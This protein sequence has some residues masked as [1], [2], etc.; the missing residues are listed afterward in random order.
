MAHQGKEPAMPI[1][2]GARQVRRVLDPVVEFLRIEAGGGAVL[3]ATTIAALLLANSPLADGYR[4]EL[5]Q[6]RLHLLSA[7]L[8]V[9][10]F[11]LANAGVVLDAAALSAAWGSRVAWASRSGCW[12]ASWPAWSAPV[13]WAMRLGWG[14]LPDDMT[15]RHLWASGPWPGSASPWPCSSPTWPTARSPASGWTRPSSPS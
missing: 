5:L 14:S 6:G 2:R 7:Y 4:L 12:S 3:L 10:L 1:R 8:V 15:N 9:P 13:R 11:A